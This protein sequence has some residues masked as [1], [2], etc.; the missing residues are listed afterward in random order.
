MIA[1]TGMEEALADQDWRLKAELNVENRGGA[2][3]RL[4]GRVRG[5]DVFGD[6]EAAVSHDVAITHDGSLLFA[7]AASDAALATARTAIEDV[8]RRD[9]V[10]AVIVLS[11]WDDDLDEWLQTDPP[12]SGEQSRAVQA[13]R[14]DGD[15]VESRTMVASSGKLIR[16]EFEQ[17]ME[18]WAAR[19]G[20]ECEV[21][22]QPHLMTTQVAFTVTGPRR[23][24]DEFARG[25]KSEEYATLRSE[26][27]VMLGGL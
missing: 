19:L 15:T 2:L 24:I 9:N 4:L 18:S 6:A 5:P 12:L 27:N 25:L 14:R 22:E 21:I 26:R 23:K 3:D 11:R 10:E 13:A 17:S 16:A 7:Y 8:L 1:T 20:L